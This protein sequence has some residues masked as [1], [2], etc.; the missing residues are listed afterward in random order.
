MKTITVALCF[1]NKF[2]F[3]FLQY[4]NCFRLFSSNKRPL[5]NF[6]EVLLLASACRGCYFLLEGN[7]ATF[8][9]L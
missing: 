5:D 8:L 6:E 1:Q 2:E 7:V 3:M 4:L 9:T